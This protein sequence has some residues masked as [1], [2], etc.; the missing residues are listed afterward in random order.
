[1]VE[2]F[3]R[4]P[5]TAESSPS[6]PT[7]GFALLAETDLP[8]FQDLNG[9]KGRDDLLNQLETKVDAKLPFEQR[10]AM[11][12]QRLQ[13]LEK[14]RF[15]AF[16][17]Q[18]GDDASCLNLFQPRRPKILGVPASLIDRGGFQFASTDAQTRQE[19]DNP[20]LILNREDEPTPTFGEQNTVVW[21]LHSGQG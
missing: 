15:Y 4:E 9:T 21:M 17:V 20:W 19:H 13:V 8:L 1:A 16:R 6:S 10:R 3:R 7:G 18:A 11:R 2:A 12:A 5:A 14:C